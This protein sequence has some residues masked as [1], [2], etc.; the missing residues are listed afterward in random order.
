M[1]ETAR[2]LSAE[3]VIEL[4]DSHIAASPDGGP[5][6]KEEDIELGRT[7]DLNIEMISA[8]WDEAESK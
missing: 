5:N 2:A 1:N 7:V 3:E 6:R 8:L 4:I